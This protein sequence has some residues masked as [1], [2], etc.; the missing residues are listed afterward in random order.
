M[1][2]TSYNKRMGSITTFLG[3]AA[4]ISLE[5]SFARSS[6]LIFPVMEVCQEIGVGCSNGSKDI[7]KIGD[8][9]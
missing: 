6:S 5:T 8:L 9:S 1:K 3:S 7:D 2:L 4:K